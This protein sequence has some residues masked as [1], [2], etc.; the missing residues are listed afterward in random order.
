M[1]VATYPVRVDGTLDPRVSRWL[2]LVKWL[3]VIPHY[4]VLA[5]LWL[6]FCVV[7]CIAFFAIL[8]TGRYPRALF[9]FNVGVL[10][11]TWR[12]SYYSYGALATDRYPPF[13]LAEVPDYPT[14][15]EVSYPE[16]LSRGL[17]LVKWWLLA[18]P[19]YVVVG[20]FVG[21]SVWGVWW[22]DNNVGVFP[23]GLIGILVLVAAVVLGVTG[24]YPQQLFDFVLGL[25]RWVLRVAAYAGLMTDE[26]PPFRLDMGGADPSSIVTLPGSAPPS[27]GGV[28]ITKAAPPP[29]GWQAGQPQP[30]GPAPR[31]WTGG[32]VVSLVL[33]SLLALVSLAVLAAAGATTWLD[34]SQRDAAGY[35]STDPHTFTTPSYAVTSDSIDLG[36]ASDLF[37]PA[38]LFG[39]V[40]IRATSNRPAGVVFVGVAPAAAVERYLGG[41]SHAVVTD[42]TNG[43]TDYR[44]AAGGPPPLPPIAARFWT[45]HT[46][47]IG[48]QSLTWRPSSGQWMIVVM[49]PS[50]RPGISVSADAG[51]TIPDL[52]WVAV[53]LWG[54]GIVLG[55]G[56]AA[57]V[58]VP[59]IRAG[60]ASAMATGR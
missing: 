57:L 45:A 40:R 24:R 59:V 29:S 43:H 15:F 14:H 42:W 30:Q 37:T 44:R 55:A 58:A 46:A 2:W 17:V 5:F 38:D 49:N 53:A 8:F 39:T 41:V 25:N 28:P 10:R 9:D 52:G 35:L 3:L 34:N 11:W 1:S 27:V 31:V 36:T 32:R 4:F 16:H 54:L 33:G 18:I 56:A 26:Y 21:G 22:A 13:T 51:A 60:R 6:A 48:T 47:G 12:V 19:H 50:G 20:I 7:S 23:G